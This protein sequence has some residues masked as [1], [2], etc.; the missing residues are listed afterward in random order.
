MCTLDF[1][2]VVAAADSA[3]ANAAI[4][5]AADPWLVNTNSTMRMPG[6]R[7]MAK[8]HHVKPSWKRS[9]VQEML[10]CRQL[11]SVLLPVILPWPLHVS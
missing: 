1:D 3:P 6:A 5:A 11:S 9:S 4:V 2:S 8:Y 7:K 10:K